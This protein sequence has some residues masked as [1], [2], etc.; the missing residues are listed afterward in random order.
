MSDNRRTDGKESHPPC[1][2]LLQYTVHKK[3]AVD[4]DAKEA[5]WDVGHCHCAARG[6][7]AL[8][9]LPDCLHPPP[10]VENTDAPLAHASQKGPPSSFEYFAMALP[11][12]KLRMAVSFMTMF[13][14]GPEV[15]FRG[16]PTVSPVTEFLCASEPLR[17][18]GP[19]PPAEMY[20]FELS[21]APPVLLME[22]ANCTLDTS[23]PESK[24]AQAFL[25]KPRPATSGL[26]ITRAPGAS[27]SRKDASVE[28]RM[29]LS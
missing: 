26:R 11:K 9:R 17:N 5:I 25:P 24:P 28:M 7:N 12:T 27:I 22:M 19:R 20:F 21:H 10:P 6:Q 23:A 2:R 29:H 16:S 1:R 15:S 3:M 4:M 18:S 8:R 14:A 13:S